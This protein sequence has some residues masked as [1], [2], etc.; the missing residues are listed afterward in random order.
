M[1]SFGAWVP[2][3]ASAAAND[4]LK[5]GGLVDDEKACLNRLLTHPDMKWFY[6]LGISS[7]QHWTVVLGAVIE[8]GTTDWGELGRA[9]KSIKSRLSH[10][11]KKSIALAR[12]LDGLEAAMRGLAAQTTVQFD[13]LEPNDGVPLFSG[14]ALYLHCGA[15]VS[16]FAKHV[17]PRLRERQIDLFA[18]PSVAEMLRKLAGV[19]S[20]MEKVELHFVVAL[21]K[22]VKTSG[23]RFRSGAARCLVVPAFVLAVTAAFSDLASRIPALR[24]LTSLTHGQLASLASSAL[25]TVVDDDSV[26]QILS[27]AKPAP[28]KSEV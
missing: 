20:D 14:N 12:E 23:G 8:L 15:E 24:R 1:D 21:E 6:D 16:K 28:D 13:G 27:R 22:G 10:I 25:N 19:A 26:R 5:R 11:Q 3:A 7:H 17:A 2:K 9:R 18:Y 4:H